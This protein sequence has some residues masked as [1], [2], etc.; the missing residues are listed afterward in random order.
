MAEKSGNNVPFQLIIASV[1]VGTVSVTGLAYLDTTRKIENQQTQINELNAQIASFDETITSLKTSLDQLSG[2]I[3]GI[4]VIKTQIIYEMVILE[5]NWFLP[6]NFFQSDVDA[7]KT[8]QTAT[9]NKVAALETMVTGFSTAITANV[10]IFGILLGFCL[11]PPLP[12]T[13]IHKLCFFFAKKRMNTLQIQILY[14]LL[15]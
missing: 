15:K 13:F 3:Q 8:A 11:P 10:S 2:S 5:N 7:V 12:M 1:V 14:V 4:E 6:F 9:D